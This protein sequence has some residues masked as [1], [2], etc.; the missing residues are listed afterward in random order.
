MAET[1]TVAVRVRPLNSTKTAEKDTEIH[2]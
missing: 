1:V 2:N